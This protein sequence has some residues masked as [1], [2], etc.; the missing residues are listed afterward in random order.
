[1]KLYIKQHILTLTDT[2]DIYDENG[3]MKYYAKCDFTLFLHQLRIYHNNQQ[4][5]HVEQH[6]KFFE[7]EFSFYLNGEYLGNIVKKVTFLRPQYYLSFNN[8]RIEGNVFGFDYQVYDSSG[9]II[10]TFS[11]ELFTIGDR[12][13]LNILDDKYEQLCVCIA[14]AVDMAICSQKD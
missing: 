12:Y 14:L 11:K 7:P 1:M 8:W 5:G 2:Y 10:M 4:I 6:F 13:C 9:N 3:D